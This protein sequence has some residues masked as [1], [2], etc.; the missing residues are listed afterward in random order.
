MRSQLGKQAPVR[1]LWK[2]HSKTLYAPGLGTLTAL[3]SA[4]VDRVALELRQAALHGEH[5][6]P[7]RLSCQ[8][9]R[10]PGN[11]TSS[12]SRLPTTRIRPT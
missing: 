11:G 9:S 6:P 12:A 1:L 5:E 3:A 10:R 4:S 7:V 2:P 8:P